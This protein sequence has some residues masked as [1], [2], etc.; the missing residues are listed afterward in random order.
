MTQEETDAAPAE[1]PE[2]GESEQD[3]APRDG[4]AGQSDEEESAEDVTELPAPVETRPGDCSDEELDPLR[5]IC[6]NADQKYHQVLSYQKEF[7]EAEIVLQRFQAREGKLTPLDVEKAKKEF[8]KAKKSYIEAGNE[9]NEGIK[10][11]HSLARIY[12]EDLLVQSLYKTYLAKL[13]ASL[14]TRNP[15]K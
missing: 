12:P 1:E 2:G 14:Q 10:Q 11:V 4:E 15:E 9:I 7:K 5:S 3:S 6:A 8:H 13:Q